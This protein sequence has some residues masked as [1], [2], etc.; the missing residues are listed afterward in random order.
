LGS[1]RLPMP[2]LYKARELSDCGQ[3]T[4]FQTALHMGF[5]EKRLEVLLAPKADI[6]NFGF[7]SWAGVS[8]SIRAVDDAVLLRKLP[9][10]PAIE[11]DGSFL[12][13][14]FQFRHSRQKH[15]Q[16]FPLLPGGCWSRE[17]STQKN[18]SLRQ[19]CAPIDD[20]TPIVNH[21]SR[22]PLFFLRY[23]PPEPS[24]V[25]HTPHSHSIV[26]GGLLVISYVT[27]LIPRTS[28]TIRFATRVRKPM[29]NGYTSAVMPSVLVTARKAQAW[30]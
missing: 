17:I 19:K 28:L 25:S 24:G 15:R 26:P 12:S 29:S 21:L 6:R 2:Y 22:N 3:R 13:A 16:E 9:S 14:L 30:S 11:I 18:Q 27:R 20:V 10:N 4:S 1:S 23:S 5:V 7:E 8:H